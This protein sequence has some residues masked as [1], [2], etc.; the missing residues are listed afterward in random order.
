MIIDAPKYA[1]THINLPESEKY[2]RIIQNV[3][4]ESRFF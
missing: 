4:E 2:I 1:I 3:D